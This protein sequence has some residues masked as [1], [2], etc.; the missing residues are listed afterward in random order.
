MWKGLRA[1]KRRRGDREI[2]KERIRGRESG[3]EIAIE[4]DVWAWKIM[5]EEQRVE[6]WV[7]WTKGKQLSEQIEFNSW[8]SRKKPIMTLNW[9][10]KKK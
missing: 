1:K 7:H 2:E 10:N 9:K 4:I 3:K 8:N 5:K 6:K